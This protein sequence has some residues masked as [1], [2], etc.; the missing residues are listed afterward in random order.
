M[1]TKPA[2]HRAE[3]VDGEKATTRVVLA[4][5]DVLLR[6]GLA[7]LL[8]RS[9]F[10]VVGQTGDSVWILPLVRELTPDLVLLD[11][12][13]PPTNTTEGLDAALEIRSEFPATGILV[14][15]AHAEVEHAMELLAT[16]QRIG[17]LLKSRVTDVDE[18]LETLGRIVRGG[19]V[20]DPAL[21]QELVSARRTNDPLAEL[22]PREREVL[23][24]MAEGRSN[25][26]IARRL[27]VTEGTVEKHVRH[28]LTK[29]SLPETDDD[30]RRVL[31]VVTFLES[32]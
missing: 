4:E 11:I 24:L 14:L 12:R 1:S 26:G 19:S 27:W 5:D 7:S 10:E 3:V 22:S 31:A 9:G 20:M 30:H 6:A 21:V 8:E 2:G 16:G 29:L 15:S 25:A 32:R 28:I 13:M 23:A 17:Y 18:F